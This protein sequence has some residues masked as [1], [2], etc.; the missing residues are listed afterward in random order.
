MYPN[1]YRRDMAEIL[2]IRYKTLY[3]QPINQSINQS[4]NPNFFY[5]GLKRLCLRNVQFFFIVVP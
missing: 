1:L 3:N 2:P 5:S 4:I